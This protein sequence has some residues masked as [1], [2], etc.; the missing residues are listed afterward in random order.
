[1]NVSLLLLAIAGVT[2][3]DPDQVRAAQ[4]GMTV[5]GTPL[6]LPVSLGAFAT[7]I[8][9]S[10]GT[11]WGLFQHYW[12][13]AKLVMTL[14]LLGGHQGLRTYLITLNTQLQSGAEVAPEGVRLVGML[15]GTLLVLVVATMLSVFKPAGRF[16]RRAPQRSGQG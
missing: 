8:V 11:P 14:A 13:V 5:I 9:L 3:R 2:A 6:I 7:G 1:M 12:V 4:F 15:S 16:P 10:L